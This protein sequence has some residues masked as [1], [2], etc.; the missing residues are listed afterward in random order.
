MAVRAVRG[1][2]QV[3]RDDP[4]TV[5][6]GT[7]ELLGEIMLRNDLAAEDLIS[8]VFTTTPDL[9]SAFPAAAARALGLVDVPLLCAAEIAV[10]EAM[11]RVVRVLAHVE[12]D[13]AAGAVR[14]VYLHGAARLRPDLRH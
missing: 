1:A 6:G 4:E 9:T 13:R 10:S 2:V 14:H 5:L 11:S 12:T 8:L 3:D 7:A